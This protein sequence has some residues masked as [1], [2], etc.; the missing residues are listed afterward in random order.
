MKENIEDLSIKFGDM[1]PSRLSIKR[2]NE[3]YVL[4]PPR[5]PH[6]V[7]RSDTEFPPVADSNISVRNDISKEDDMKRQI[8]K[9]IIF[10][11][12]AS[13]TSESKFFIS[14]NDE[15]KLKMMERLSAPNMAP[16]LQLNE[17]ITVKKIKNTAHNGVIKR[18]LHVPSFRLFDI[19]V[20]LYFDFNGLKL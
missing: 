17:L 13:N 6:R 8:K 20:K 16:V 11:K 12:K 5:R 2:K 14:N 1:S 18:M 9:M 10:K 15:L 7:Q 4:S 3:S 19:M